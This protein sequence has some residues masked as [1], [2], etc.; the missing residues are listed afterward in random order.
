MSVLVELKSLRSLGLVT[1]F[2]ANVWGFFSF[3]YKK[4]HFL[5]CTFPALQAFLQI[6]C[7]KKGR[8]WESIGED[9]RR[10]VLVC[11]HV[12]KQKTLRA[13]HVH[14]SIRMFA[15]FTAK[16]FWNKFESIPRVQEPRIFVL[17]SLSLPSPLVQARGSNP[18]FRP[19]TFTFSA[20]QLTFH[21]W[22]CSALFQKALRT[23]GYKSKKIALPLI[24]ASRPFLR[25]LILSLSS[26]R[27][28]PNL[29]RYFPWIRRPHNLVLSQ[30][31]ASSPSVVGSVPRSSQVWFLLRNLF[32]CLPTRNVLLPIFLFL[33]GKS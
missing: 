16:S 33:W 29:E 8:I 19:P 4:L 5:D 25:V 22:K 32:F 27:P 15:S 13:N 20:F 2:M 23:A 1:N 26:S 17:N 6:C 10:L 18:C 7:A 3:I 14:P 28:E 30:N 21:G 11:L 12:C 24:L 9:L 31:A